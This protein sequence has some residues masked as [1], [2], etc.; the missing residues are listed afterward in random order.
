MFYG[1]PVMRFKKAK[2]N[3]RWEAIK[4]RLEEG[5]IASGKIA[6]VE[7]DKM[8][9]EALGKLGYAGKDTAEKVSTIKPGQLV[10]IDDVREIQHF[11]HQIVKD[12][13]HEIGMDEIKKAVATYERV[14]RGIEMID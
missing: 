6:I 3:P 7:A 4:K 13:T 10:G 1:T 9:N 12:P 11:F 14:F 2:Y 5:S 8:L